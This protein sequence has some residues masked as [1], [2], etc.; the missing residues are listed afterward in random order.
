[1]HVTSVEQLCNNEGERER[2]GE[3]EKERVHVIAGCHRWVAIIVFEI[4]V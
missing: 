1:M 2:E 4:H 3:R